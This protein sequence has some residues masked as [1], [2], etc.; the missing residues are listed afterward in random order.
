MKYAEFQEQIGDFINKDNL[1]H[2][3]PSFIRYGQDLLETDLRLE[4]M[5]VNETND[6]A[7]GDQSF[8]EPDLFIEMKT[9]RLIA[10][11]TFTKYPPLIKKEWDYFVE[12][13]LPLTD[14][15]RPKLYARTNIIETSEG[16]LP[17][18]GITAVDARSFI[19]DRPSSEAYSIEMSFY[20][21]E[22]QMSA[23]EA[24][25]WWLTNA[26]EAFLYAALVK[27]SGY[28]AKDD[29][30]IKIWADLYTTAKDG[31][32]DKDRRARSGGEAPKANKTW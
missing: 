28:L 10:V 3:I 13:L 6:I 16:S 20:R 5:I 30:R 4:S 21:K 1:D 22:A 23:D 18:T 2:I 8:L 25:N 12:N 15:G 31:V 9:V 32:E 17:D 24:A 27:A 19:F 26:E 11:S 29:P 7:I 14:S